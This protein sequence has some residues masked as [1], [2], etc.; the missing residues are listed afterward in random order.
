MKILVIG[1]GAVGSH[2]VEHEC[3][4]GIHHDE[5]DGDVGGYSAVVN[6]AG[7]A[8]DGKCGLD[9]YELVM[10][11]NVDFPLKI[12]NACVKH[13]V[14]FIHLSTSGVYRNQSEWKSTYVGLKES[15]P[16][17]PHNFSCVSKLLAESVLLS[18]LDENCSLFIFRIPWMVIGSQYI[19]RSKIWQRVQ[20]TYTSVLEV[21]VL[22]DACIRVVGSYNSGIYNVASG[23]VWFPS[24]FKQITGV[25]LPMRYDV[26]KGMTSACPLDTSKFKEVFHVFG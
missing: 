15:D 1:L 19:E 4:E 9:N 10:D 18:Y 14:S 21:N 2:L 7:I 3:F 5:F 13:N 24:F 25:D 23:V 22:T 20:A 6:C 8:G 16:V 17:Y 11:A 26:E 12:Y